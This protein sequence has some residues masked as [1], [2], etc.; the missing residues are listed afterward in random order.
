LDRVAEEVEAY[1]A[2]IADN[3][4]S[5]PNQPFTDL[6]DVVELLL[7]YKENPYQRLGDMFGIYEK[8]SRKIVLLIS[9]QLKLDIDEKLK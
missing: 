2:S 6:A 9:E 7:S 8:A 5:K 4:D 3:T 1:L